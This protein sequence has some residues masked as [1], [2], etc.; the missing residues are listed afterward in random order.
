LHFF[1]K[2]GFKLKKELQNKYGKGKKELVLVRE[3]K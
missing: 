1:C 3:I 2:Y